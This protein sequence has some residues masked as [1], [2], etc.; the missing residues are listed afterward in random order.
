M[1]DCW[2]FASSGT[3][4]FPRGKAGQSATLYGHQPRPRIGRCQ[5]GG[6]EREGHFI[7]P[8]ACHVSRVSFFSFSFF[9]LPVAKLDGST[10]FDGIGA[11]SLCLHHTV[12][13]NSTQLMTTTHN[14]NIET[15]IAVEASKQRSQDRPIQAHSRVGK[16]WAPRSR[17]VRRHGYYK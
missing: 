11:G 3:G 15:I 8:G 4:R 14:N 13:L 10:A 6:G 1:S 2:R 17:P 16:C 12:Y 7:G 5:P 9:F